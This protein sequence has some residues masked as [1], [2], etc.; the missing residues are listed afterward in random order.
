VSG[1]AAHGRPLPLAGASPWAAS[2]PRLE[3]HV[4]SWNLTRLC[5]LR[6]RHC[7]IEAGR[8]RKGE[9]RGELST[10]ECLRVVDEIAEVNPN[11]LLILT[12]GEPL[13]R[14]DVFEIARYASDRGLWVVVGTNGVLLTPE[15]VHRMTDAGIR[16]VSLSLD[17]LDPATHDR[18]RGVEGAWANTVEG[19]RLLNEAGL[20][21]IVQTTVGRHNL[22]EIE[23][24]ARMACELGA[25]VFNLYFLVPTGRGA[26]VSDI[27]PDEYEAVMHR[28]RAI[29]EEFRGRMLV[30]SKC[31]P[32]YQRV[33]YEHDPNSPFLKT[34]GA[35]A[36][37]CPAGTH[38]CGIRP[39]GEVTPCP[40]L[41][42]YGGNLRER[43]FREIWERSEVFVR[44]RERTA[45]GGRCGACEF[46]AVCGGCRARAFGATG[47]YMAEDPWCTYAPGRHG[48]VPIRFDDATTYGLEER[49]EMRWT[50][51]AEARLRSAPSFVRGMVSRRVEAYARSRGYT[52]VTPAVLDEVRREVLGGRIA[53][54][55]PF[56]RRMLEARERGGPPGDGRGG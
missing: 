17:A 44:I 34:F 52:E 47:D 43:S 45:L 5:N 33:L 21:F 42:V 51:E 23:A 24:I 10:E 19:S 9:L 39:T 14:R 54:A 26:Y 16:G 35:G 1:S 12:G 8:V 18:F 41:P 38:Y 40:Y 15:L 50:P 37:G 48:G 2:A 29:Q 20:P 30:N 7:Y 25:R 11:A 36:G 55:P 3:T 4:I 22:H 32:H 27:G 46:R 31:A 28:L 56:V 49:R 6:C 13:L 53:G